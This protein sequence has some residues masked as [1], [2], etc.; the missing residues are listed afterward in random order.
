MC[1]DLIIHLYSLS[2]NLSDYTTHQ[3]VRYLWI[4]YPELNSCWHNNIY[5]TVVALSHSRNESLGVWA[6]FCFYE[7]SELYAKFVP[8]R[9]KF[10]FGFLV[11]ALE[12]FHVLSRIA[13]YPATLKGEGLG[14]EI[15]VG[16]RLT[17]CRRR[18]FV[19]CMMARVWLYTHIFSRNRQLFY[20]Y[21]NFI[22]VKHYFETE[23]IFK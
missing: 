4:K 9:S 8:N 16:G 19:D 12:A 15:I 17:Q 3:Y 22:N 10:C 18:Q 1:I 6:S 13:L 20:K 5:Q 21:Q 11:K 2:K 7:S 14:G 23:S